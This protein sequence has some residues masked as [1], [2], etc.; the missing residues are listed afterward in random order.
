[1]RALW[2]HYPKDVKA[3]GIG[4]QYLWG[5]DLLIAPVFKREPQRGMSICPGEIGT[6]GG[7]M[8]KNRAEK[9]F[10]VK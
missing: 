4:S 2:L 6:I 3:A 9:L 8:K 5:R 1:M 7:P 10:P